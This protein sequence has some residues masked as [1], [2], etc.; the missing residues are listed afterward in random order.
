MRELKKKLREKVV[1]Y[2]TGVQ[3]EQID[4]ELACSLTEGYILPWERHEHG[5]IIA[6]LAC[7]FFSLYQNMTVYRGA[8]KAM[9][10][11]ANI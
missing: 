11:P 9:V 3:E 10:I 8:E 5:W 4:E 2:N 6:S 7:C 1:Q